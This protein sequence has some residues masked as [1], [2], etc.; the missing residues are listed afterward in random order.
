MKNGVCYFANYKA[1]EK[2]IDYFLKEIFSYKEDMYNYVWS[3]YKNF[4]YS[5]KYKFPVYNIKK[6]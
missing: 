6:H 2:Y 4:M 3:A 1:S 5:D